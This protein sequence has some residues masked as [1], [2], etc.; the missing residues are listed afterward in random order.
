ML[1]PP[2]LQLQVKM[3]LHGAGVH[4]GAVDP[5]RLGGLKHVQRPTRQ[6]WLLQE[7]PL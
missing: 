2:T 5:P 3:E 6:S 1:Q 7:E 4:D